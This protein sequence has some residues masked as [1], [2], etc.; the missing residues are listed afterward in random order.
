[1][2]VFEGLK[3]DSV[4]CLPSDAYGFVYKITYTS[5]QVYYGKKNLYKEV[6]LPELKSGIQRPNS[7]RIGKNKNGKRVYLD[8]VTKETDWLTYEGSSELS[9]DLIVESKEILDYAVS[10]RELTYLETKRLFWE[11]AIEDPN[12]INVCIGNMFFRDNLK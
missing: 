12:C 1:M 8:V 3:V 9:E 11:E 6:K 2:W 10:K 4:D 5:G 7:K